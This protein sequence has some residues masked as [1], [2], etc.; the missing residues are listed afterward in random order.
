[1]A[2]PLRVALV[3]YYV[4]MGIGLGA[5][6][7]GLLRGLDA[8]DCP[9]R[10]TVVTPRPRL[11][12]LERIRTVT[13]PMPVPPL[14][15]R[16]PLIYWDQLAA[17]SAV[18]LIRPDIV[19]WLQ[20]R[21]S[22]LPAAPRTVMSLAD[23]IPWAPPLCGR[24]LKHGYA[25]TYAGM[26]RR[27][28]MVM[29]HSL[30][31]AHDIAEFLQVDRERI[32]VNALAAEPTRE[33]GAAS[34]PTV[35]PPYV[36]F[37]GGSERRKNGARMIEAFA[38]AALPETIR[39]VVVGWIHPGG[40]DDDDLAACVASLAPAT[41]ERVLLVGHVSDERMRALYGAATLF[42]FPS[43]YEGFGLPV[44]EA[45]QRGV[46]V[47]TSTTTSLPEV[48]GDA[49]KLVD[50]TDVD[51]LARALEEVVGDPGLHA[52]LAERGRVQAGR[53]SWHATAAETVAAYEQ[54]AGA[55]A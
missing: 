48:V 36:L 7:R 18:K 33:D 24:A 23:A 47:I 27:A 39:L 53:F 6:A 40:D 50:P 38:R 32:V 21:T 34:P 29:T 55:G 46:P 31:A 30:H 41:R 19:H 42:A 3:S 9:H 5:Y 28:D 26:T 11:T 54:L 25:R 52:E 14:T 44:L 17:W 12:G 49:A 15:P 8:L 2:R 13:L 16:V 37:V 4:H 35:E 45:M 22:L 43:L 20:P 10:F 51:A 1:M